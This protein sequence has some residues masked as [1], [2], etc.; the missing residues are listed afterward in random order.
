MLSRFAACGFCVLVYVNSI[1]TSASMKDSRLEI[2]PR[3]LFLPTLSLAPVS[4][5]LHHSPVFTEPLAASKP[6][7]RTR[8]NK[9][10]SVQN[11]V[12]PSWLNL[13]LF[14]LFTDRVSPSLVNKPILYCYTES[15]CT[16]LVLWLLVSCQAVKHTNT[17]IV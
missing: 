10:Q 3:P 11:S 7:T 5:A 6:E 16:F 13:N 2:Q 14:P 15:V 1:G 8:I 4:P 17:T 9:I 12:Q